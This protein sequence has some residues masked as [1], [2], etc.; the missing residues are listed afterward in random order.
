MRRYLKRYE[1]NI[2][3]S[4]ETE[5]ELEFDMS[6]WLPHLPW[7]GRFYCTIEVQWAIEDNSFSYA[8]T[9]CTGGRAG[10]HY[11][12]GVEAEDAHIVGAVYDDED[13]EVVLTW[14]EIEYYS[15]LS[16]DRIDEREH[17]DPSDL[18]EYYRDEAV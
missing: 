11:C 3:M 1:R 5:H 2:Y 15:R 13:N 14:R 16:L 4:Y 17:P 9:H 10:I 18:M 12:Y 6:D 8:G 7:R